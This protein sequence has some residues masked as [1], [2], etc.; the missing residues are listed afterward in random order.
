MM[1]DPAA[2]A[3]P[4]SERYR[5]AA[6]IRSLV[7]AGPAG[8]FSAFEGLALEVFGFQYGGNAA[9]RQF[10]CAKGATPDSVTHWTEIPA[11]PTEAFKG[12]IVTSFP[13]E[14][15]VMAQL[16]S[17]TT[18]RGERGKIFKDE[19]GR[20]LVFAANRE[21]TG[22][23]LFPDVAAGTRCRILI[24]AP[25]PT[26]APS[27]GMAMGM[28]ETRRCFGTDDSRFLMGW[29]GIDMRALV[30]A[31][32]EAEASGVP[33]ALVGSTSAFAFLFRA[34]ARK[35][36]SFCLPKGSRVCDGGG[37]RGRFG[38]MTRKDYYRMAAEV[39]GLDEAHCVNTLG[40]AESATNYFDDSLRRA[41]LP[42]DATPTGTGAQ[43]QSP[44]A[45]KIP[46][47]WTRVACV[48]LDDLSP[49]AP[50]EI[51]L[52][53]HFDL[54]NLPTVLG[55]Q[56]DNLGAC[57]ADGSFE[58]LGRA[59]IIDGRISRMPAERAVG[60]MGDRRVFRLLEAYVNFSIDFKSGRFAEVEREP[61]E[62]AATDE[63]PAQCECAV[64]N[65]ELVAGTEDL[66][67]RARARQALKAAR[68]GGGRP[69]RPGRGRAQHRS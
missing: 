1:V 69:S 13:M 49:A 31:L 23:W 34:A 55:V 9:Y 36:L 12:S 17:G 11:F 26:M 7:D 66:E 53:Q 3:G 57:Y 25:S 51:G 45:R 48:S 28:E 40:M 61:E 52:L 59:Q 60:P 14:E 32:R 10:C 29:S 30:A 44:P 65:E 37:Y 62:V 19:I 21:M 2:T 43:E 42:R 20:Q 56:A 8:D 67:A 41:L 39:F 15:A 50:G 16:T 33:V 58:I 24:L 63:V 6:R 22:Y 54:C 68:P 18:A 5:L 38:E 35:R 64:V 4:D 27:M 47:A 46:P